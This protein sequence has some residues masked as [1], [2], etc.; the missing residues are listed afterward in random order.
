MLALLMLFV[1]MLMMAYVIWRMA[2]CFRGTKSFLGK[3]IVLIPLSLIL[4]VLWSTLLLGGFLPHSDL[5]V[6]I[7]KFSNYWL[8]FFIYLFFF[9]LVTD[10][11]VLI[12]KLVKKIRKKEV[13]KNPRLYAIL[14]ALVFLLSIGFTAYGLDH[15]NKI[16][17]NSYEI[18]VDKS[19]AGREDLNI[20][21]VSD[22]HLGYSIGCDMM[23]QM[24]EKVNALEPDIIIM[25]GDIVDNEYE[26]LDDPER[27]AEII[28]SMKST[29]GTY[30]IYGN[31]DVSALLIG[32][33]SVT[34]PSEQFRDP[35]V[36]EFVKDCGITMLEDEVVTIDDAFY[37]IG[38]LDGERAG[39]GTSDRMTI[40]EL[41]GDL[42]K[43]KP[44]IMLSHEPDEISENAAN[45]MDIQLSGHTHAGQFFPL[46]LTM[47]FKWENYWGYKQVDQLHEFV[48]SGIGVYGPDMR[49]ATDS[50]VMQI[51]VHFTK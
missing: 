38:R 4:I 48:S 35:R 31:H 7:H 16:T 39:D 23:E 24:V 46:T 14:S 6:A 42:D 41:T 36:E 12:F 20:V 21:L 5:Q 17:T 26:A 33:F 47:P 2:H 32:G 10:I 18:T 45:G 9:T 22:F 3:K 51:K 11:L 15:A 37:L 49:V 13:Q 50:E 1:Y 44:C 25:G 27:L 8:G 30:G 40:E 29:Y 43:S 28:S 34:T 19:C